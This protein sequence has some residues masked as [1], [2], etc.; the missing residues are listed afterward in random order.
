MSLKFAIA[1]HKPLSITIHD[2]PCVVTRRINGCI[3][4]HLKFDQEIGLSQNT[5]QNVLMMKIDPRTCER[6]L[7]NC[8]KKP[9]KN[10]GLQWR[11][12]P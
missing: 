6:S 10:S 1:V 3:L 7:C 5:K 8:V 4:R 12:N 9:E 2:S 11:L